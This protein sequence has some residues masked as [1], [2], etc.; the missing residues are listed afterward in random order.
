MFGSLQSGRRLEILH[1]PIY[2]GQSKSIRQRVLSHFSG[3]H[4]SGKEMSVSQQVRLIDWIECA[5]E[6]KS[7][8]CQRNH[9]FFWQTHS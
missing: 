5:G 7:H 1:Y 8:A 3:Y 6:I 9:D 2:V 4:A